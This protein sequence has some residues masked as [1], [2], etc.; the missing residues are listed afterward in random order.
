[1]PGSGG[2]PEQVAKLESGEQ[3]HDWP[4]LLPNRDDLLFTARRRSLGDAILVQSL[5]TG[6][7]RIVL[8]N[9]SRGTYI[10]TRHLLFFRAVA[11][12]AVPFDPE[13]LL[14][15]GPEFILP[16]RVFVDVR[17]FWVNPEF[18]VSPAGTLVYAPARDNKYSVV[19]VDRAGAARPLPLPAGDYWDPRLSPDGRFLA[20][21]AVQGSTQLLLWLWDLARESPSHLTTAPVNGMVPTWSDMSPTWSP[22]G[23]LLVFTRGHLIGGTTLMWMPTDASAEPQKLYELPKGSVFA[24]S[25]SRDAKRLALI[26]YELGG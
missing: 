15:I 11:L 8:E 26:E 9:A 7:R 19:M 17:S 16:Y 20:V 6:K 24:T 23:R 22:D 1:M 14:V 2:A 4:Q 3:G 18:A 5:K 25:W 21:S 13:R 12:W 10:P